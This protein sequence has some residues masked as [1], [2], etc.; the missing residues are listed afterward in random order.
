M[1]A[2]QDL[3]QEVMAVCPTGSAEARLDAELDVGYS[4]IVLNCRKTDTDFAGEKIPPMVA[5]R[6][7][8][9]LD[10][11]RNDMHKN[12]GHLWNRCTI[13]IYG[14]GKFQFDVSY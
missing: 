12:T 6:I 8:Q 11:I 14:N 10:D 5:W 7:G 3:A 2:I 1:D 9:V 4:E 13:T